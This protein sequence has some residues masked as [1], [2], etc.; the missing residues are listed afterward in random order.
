MGSVGGG[1]QVVG[2]ATT[3]CSPPPAQE[4]R[5][6]RS[7]NKEARRHRDNSNAAPITNVFCCYTAN[8]LFAWCCCLCRPRDAQPC[9][10]P[11][12]P[13]CGLQPP[14]LAT[15]PY[16]RSCPRDIFLFAFSLLFLLAF[17]HHSVPR[18]LPLPPTIQRSVNILKRGD[19][20]GG[21]EDLRNADIAFP[22]LS[23]PL[24][25]AA[26][27]SRPTSSRVSRC[28]PRA[29]HPRHIL[30]THPLHSSSLPSLCTIS[31]SCIQ[32]QGV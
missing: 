29:S 2:V 20:V 7:A 15:A 25:F 23:E 14:H 24:S 30:G 4:S 26:S 22:R 21:R 10:R 1:W 28:L 8:F 32:T 27:F 12:P 6:R 19:A 18:L 31:N 11:P 5:R 13:P 17:F 16:R 9:G 3:L